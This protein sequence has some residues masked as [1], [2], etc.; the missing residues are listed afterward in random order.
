MIDAARCSEHAVS[1]IDEPTRGYEEA[2]VHLPLTTL[3]GVVSVLTPGVSDVTVLSF[4][5]VTEGCH[6]MLLDQQLMDAAEPGDMGLSRWTRVIGMLDAE[7]P[8]PVREHLEALIDRS[9]ET[10]EVG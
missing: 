2:L 6:P 9:P 5:S 3:N 4:S 1:A 7:P 10:P 8:E